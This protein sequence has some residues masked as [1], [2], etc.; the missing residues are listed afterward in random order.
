MINAKEK[1]LI[2]DGF[3]R[4]Y[5]LDHQTWTPYRENIFNINRKIERRHR[6]SFGSRTYPASASISLV[7]K[8][9]SVK[10]ILDALYQTHRPYQVKDFLVINESAFLGQALAEEYREELLESFLDFNF[11]KFQRFD[12]CEMVSDANKS[13]ES[14]NQQFLDS[15]EVA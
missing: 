12:Y 11:D 8:Y 5:L 13:C 9:Y 2:E 4:L 3:N 15:I 1:K 7:A 6:D 10:H 14:T